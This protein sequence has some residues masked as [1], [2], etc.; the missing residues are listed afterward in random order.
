MTESS[1]LDTRWAYLET[2]AAADAP[3]ADNPSG[4]YCP[5]CRAV[6]FYHCAWPE[7]CGAMRRMTPKG[8]V[9]A[10]FAQ[11]RKKHLA[12]MR[13]YQVGES[14]EHISIAEVERENGSPKPGDMIAR[15]PADHRDQWLV[16]AAYFAA[17]FD[18]L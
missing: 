4:L 11:Y 3:L 10:E 6:G 2:E 1:A 14:M 7:Y 8:S 18:P 12:E 17:N 5:A 16:S 9:M 13:P 15:N